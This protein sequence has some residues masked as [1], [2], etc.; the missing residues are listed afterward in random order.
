MMLHRCGSLVLSRPEWSGMKAAGFRLGGSAAL[1]VGV[2]GIQNFLLRSRKDGKATISTNICRT[3]QWNRI[4]ESNN[5]ILNGSPGAGKTTVGQ[6]VG[7]KLGM[8]VLDVDNDILE[9]VWGMPVSEKLFEV[10]GENFVEKEGEALLTFTPPPDTVVTLTGSNAMHDEAMSHISQYGPILFLDVKNQDILQRLEAMKVNRIVGQE[11]GVSMTEIL[12]YR[13]QFYERSY[14]ARIVCEA[15]EAQESI[16]GKIVEAIA[17]LENNSPYISTRDCGKSS[18]K[19]FLSA[20]L[21]GLAEDGGLFVPSGPLPKMTLKQWER[22]VPCTYQQRAQRILEQWI[23]P[24]DLHPSVLNG[25]IQK[26]YTTDA[27]QSEDVVPV[28]HLEGNQ[29]L[30]EVFHGPT[31]SFKD[32]PL[33]LMPHFFREAVS[34]KGDA[35]YLI[36]VATSGDTGSAVLDGF[37]ATS[38]TSGD[39]DV[40]VMVFYPEEG[41]SPVQKSLM[42]AVNS[43]NVRV[44][45]VES[46]FDFCQSAIKDIFSSETCMLR[47]SLLNDFNV[48][49]SAANSINWGRL[50]PQIVYHASSY[51]DLVRQGVISVG[52]PVDLCVPTGNFGNM[53]GA[54]YAKLM[55]IPLRRL[56]CASNVNN[57]LTDFLHNGVY[58]LRQRPLRVTMS[59]AIDI[60]KSSNLERL[61]FLATDCN[62]PQVASFY[63]QLQEERF[64]QVPD[65]VL[66]KIR[67]DYGFHGDWCDE[68]TCSKAIKETFEKT[69]YL[70]DPHTAISKVVA[71]RHPSDDGAPML[72]CSTAHHGKFASD[73]LGS[74][75]HRANHSDRPDLLLNRLGDLNPRPGRHANLE[76]SVRNPRVQ[77]KVVDASMESMT[78]EVH[79]F[80]EERIGN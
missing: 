1:G 48:K 62:G 7:R 73:V 66:T 47:H 26:A 57:V 9:S 18:G 6:I 30:V 50:L 79:D 12:A 3:R 60:L 55:G 41:V 78:K 21:Q 29:H 17:R 20:V 58:D 10:G 72:L 52:D 28:T 5:I 40:S 64:F 45:G 19:D 56:L 59:P 44:I 42:T 23:H 37:G 22:L 36:L 46:D 16:A 70:L 38:V 33:Q 14:S 71:D 76:R 51:L 31:A 68:E 34:Q 63:E 25:M 53:L 32:A 74:L 69:G 54:V 43:P 24:A 65:N 80:V 75:G 67:E 4:K 61:L 13:Q 2:V 27:F 11:T 35:K 8:D 49:L 77:K 15:N 39:D